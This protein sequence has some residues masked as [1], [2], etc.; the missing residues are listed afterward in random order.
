MQAN[1]RSVLIVG[2]GTAGWMTAAALAHKLVG[3]GIAIRLV[4]SAEIGTVGVGEST[5]SH[6]RAYNHA[7]GFDEAEFMAATNA[8]FKL[9][10]EFRDWGRIGDAYMHPFGP[11]GSPIAGVPFIQSWSRLRRAGLAGNLDAWSLPIAAARAGRFAHP[12][13]DPAVLASTYSYAYQFDAGLYAGFLR[14]FAEA[15]GVVRSEGKVVAVALAEP[16]G[17]V[18]EIRLENGETIGADLFIDCSG[19]RGLLIEGALKAGYESWSHWLPCDRAWAVP[20]NNVGPIGPYTR[21]TA[22]EAGWMW[23]IPLQ[24]RAGNGHVFSSGFIGDDKALSDLLGQLDAPPLAE[25]RQLRFVP[26]KRRQQWTGNTVA[27]G[28]SAGFLEPLESTSIHMIQV[29]IET[30]LDLFPTADWKASDAAEFNRRMSLEYDRV[31]DFI[32]LHYCASER[33]DSEMWRHVRHMALPDS[34]VEKME[35]F[36][37]RGVVVSYRHGMFL[38]P[39]WHAVYA[40]QNIVPEHSDPLIEAADLHDLERAAGVIADE[41]RAV[42]SA[43]PSHAS[44]LDRKPAKAAAE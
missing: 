39:S 11:F 40:G 33:D 35:L 15:R 44:A 9:A 29:A 4:E 34:L 24:H 3:T 14:A 28:L 37:A 27:I 41:I 6:I 1:I 22:K 32:I 43:M 30:L 17:H 19:F 31:R 16:T 12:D 5:V 13:A 8:T 42:V 38:E 36:R 21:A 7:L 10:I 23:R 2:G 18:R 25:P 26:G 20:C